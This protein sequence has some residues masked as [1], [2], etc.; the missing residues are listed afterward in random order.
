MQYVTGLT[1][2][3]TT[4]AKIRKTRVCLAANA[5]QSARH[6]IDHLPQRWNAERSSFEAIIDTSIG[7]VLTSRV[8]LLYTVHYS[9][10]HTKGVV[11]DVWTYMRV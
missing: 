5:G 6:D 9:H 8:R 11:L 3:P 10:R 2:V 1:F 7:S 4:Q